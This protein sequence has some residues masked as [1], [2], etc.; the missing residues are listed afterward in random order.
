MIYA[1]FPL[2]MSKVRSVEPPGECAGSLGLFRT[3]DQAW[4]SLDHFEAD[5]FLY[6]FKLNH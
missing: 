5:L 6:A 4:E 3:R 2:Q 1:C